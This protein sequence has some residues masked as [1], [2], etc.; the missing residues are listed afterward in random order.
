MSVVLHLETGEQE[1]LNLSALVLFAN[2]AS[3]GHVWKE[4]V[5]VVS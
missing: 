1:A 3:P 2:I 5:P 4:N